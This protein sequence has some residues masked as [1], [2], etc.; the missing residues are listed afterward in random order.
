MRLLAYVLSLLILSSCSVSNKIKIPKPPCLYPSRNFDFVL[1][2][3]FHFSIN[4][5][6]FMVPRGFATDLASTP[7]FLWSIYSPNKSDTIPGAIIHDYLYFCP[8]DFS[9]QQAD[10]ILYDALIYKGTSKSF[11]FKYWLAVR[12]FGF[13]N[14]SEGA[15]CTHAYAQ[16]KNTNGLTRSLT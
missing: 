9:R 3:N 11:A 5:K 15:V 4:D 12:A 8:Q 16:T 6:N 1:C 2:K 7:R 14:F 13:R 10:S